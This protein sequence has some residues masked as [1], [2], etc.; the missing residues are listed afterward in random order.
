MK[1][2]T[3]EDL[4]E[5]LDEEKA[6]EDKLTSIAEYGVRDAAMKAGR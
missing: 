2:Q 3:L 5:S 4:Q 6:A 1:L